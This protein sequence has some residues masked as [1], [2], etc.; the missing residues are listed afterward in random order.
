[1]L[2]AQKFDTG[3]NHHTSMHRMHIMIAINIVT[4]VVLR[5]I[6]AVACYSTGVCRSCLCCF[7]YLLS[8]CFPKIGLPRSF[9]SSDW[10]Q[11]ASVP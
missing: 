3:G 9:K 7:N 6:V 5:A 11:F 2:C 8:G 4:G 1:M 10:F